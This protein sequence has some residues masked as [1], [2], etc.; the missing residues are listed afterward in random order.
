MLT[1]VEAS[2]TFDLLD[3]GNGISRWGADVLSNLEDSLRTEMLGSFTTS[4]VAIPANIESTLPA[5]TLTEVISPPVISAPNA[6]EV[7]AAL[8]TRQFDSTVSKDVVTLE[9][10]SKPRRTASSQNSRH[11]QTEEY[12]CP[13]SNC[14]H[15]RSG[16][17]WHREDHFDQYLKGVHKQSSVE[18]LRAKP[19][20]ALTTQS[21]TDTSTS[22]ENIDPFRKPKRAIEADS[23]R[24]SMEGLQQELAGERRL[25]LQ[26]EQET[27]A[28]RQQ[29]QNFE[30]RLEKS[31][32]RVDRLMTLLEKEKEEANDKI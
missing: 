32:E 25:R 18:R 1:S 6:N 23:N 13:Y 4:D 12:L 27:Q 19:A 21:P 15:S 3:I 28:M 11:G 24:K 8:A 2:F 9:A 26:A 7:Q 29:L 30:K 16:S 20:V 5:V 31:E 14:N 17:G 22:T 10:V